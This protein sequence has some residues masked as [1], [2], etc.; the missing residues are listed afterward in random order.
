MKKYIFYAIVIVLVACKKEEIARVRSPFPG[1]AFDPATEALPINQ[2]QYIGSHN[3]YRLKTE[4]AIFKLVNSIRGILPS[5]LDPRGWDYTHIPI[6]DQ[7]SLGVRNLELDIYN[8]PAG[9]RYY[10]RLGNALVGKPVASGFDE[11]RQPGMKMLHIP[12]FDYNTH[13]LSFKSALRALKSWSDLNYQHLPIFVLVELKTQTVGDVIPIFTKALPFTAGAVDSID[14][15]VVEVFGAGSPKIFRPDDLRGTYPTVR[16]AVLSQGWPTVAAMRGKIIF[17][18]YAN[19]NYPAGHPTLEGRQ[20]FQF[21]SESSPYAAFIKMDNAEDD[22]AK[23]QQLVNAG[24]FVRSRTDAETT[25]ARTGDY[26]KR[27]AAFSSGAQILSTDYYIPD[28]R[29][30]KPGWTFYHVNFDEK[31]YARV[32]VVNAPPAQ[33]GKYMRE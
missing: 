20:M 9:G 11:L 21:A 22:P 32:N 24:F 4:S 5:N 16:D 18:L 33:I 28:S 31:S 30:G 6:T 14:Q 19:E 2:L 8:D 13:H 7:L 23:V 26:S 17:V 27:D 25:N 12:D 29:A 3:S 10:N 15:E 1:I